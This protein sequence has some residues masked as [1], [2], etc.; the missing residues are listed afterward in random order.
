MDRIILV[1]PSKSHEL[2]ALDYIRELIDNDPTVHGAG[3][4]EEYVDDYMAWLK[5]VKD[6][7]QGI[8]L[9]L[10]YVPASTYFAIREGDNRIVGSV[11]IRHELNEHLLINGGNIGYEVRPTER[12]KGYATEMLQLALEKCRDLGLVK[13]LVTCN[14]TNTGS[15]KT[16]QKNSGI[17]ENEIIDSQ[18]NE[19]VQRYW[20]D[21][22]YA[23]TQ[24]QS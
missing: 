10:G 16:I 20:I 11:N 14:K 5:T 8:N 17:L 15:A 9:P 1:E 2:E 18:S 23:L 19:L 4:L 22:E 12:R 6:F 13:V 3:G 21:V 7:S 24:R